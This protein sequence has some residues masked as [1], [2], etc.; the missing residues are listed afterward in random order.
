[1]IMI[2]I[3]MIMIINIIMMMMIII[4]IIINIIIIIIIITIEY[5]LDIEHRPPNSSPWRIKFL[6]LSCRWFLGT[7]P[8]RALY[9]ASASYSARP[10]SRAWVTGWHS[11]S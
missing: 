5:L 8:R 7:S 6:V 1:M 10:V 2:N 4:I 11:V 3:I 9:K